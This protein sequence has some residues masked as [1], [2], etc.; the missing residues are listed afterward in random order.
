[1][2]FDTKN[3]RLTSY[4]QEQVSDVDN[5]NKSE[6]SDIPFED[7]RMAVCI[8]GAGNDSNDSNDSDDSDDSDYGGYG[9]EAEI[10]LLDFSVVASC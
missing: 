5:I 8:F 7:Y 2:I 6:F 4:K 9:H 3:R 10:E 1:M